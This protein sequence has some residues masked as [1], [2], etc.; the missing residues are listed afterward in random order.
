MFCQQTKPRAGVAKI[1]SDDE[2]LFVTT[3]AS[4]S[5]VFAVAKIDE[6]GS[7]AL[8]PHNL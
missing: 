8:S 1:P 2:E 4:R 3:S 6:A 5:H 7:R